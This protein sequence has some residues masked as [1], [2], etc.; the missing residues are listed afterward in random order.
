MLV[1]CMSPAFAADGAAEKLR[2]E[3][4]LT[5]IWKAFADVSLRLWKLVK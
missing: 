1:M 4:V 5:K 3:L 2:F